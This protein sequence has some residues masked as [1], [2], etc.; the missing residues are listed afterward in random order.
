MALEAAQPARVTSRTTYTCPMHPEVEQ[1]EP[2]SCPL[3][4][5]DL[6]PRRVVTRQCQEDP[7]LRQMTRRFW[8]AVALGIPV[9]L[10]AMLPMWGVPIDQWLGTGV[11]GWLQL[12]LAT[13]VVAWCGAPFFQRGARSL[14]TGHLNMFTL[15]ALGTGAAYLYSLMA[16]LLPGSLPE[17]FRKGGQV[18]LYF[19]A[20]AMITVLVLMGQV[21]ELHHRHRTGAAIRELLALAPPTAR[22]VREGQD[23]T[24]PLD[25][26][27]AGDTLRV[28]PGE[29]VPVDGELLEGRSRVDQSMITGESVPVERVPGDTVI[30]GTLNQTGAFLM[31][32]D[33]VGADTF[34]A[35]IVEMVSTAQRSRAQSN[36]WPMSWPRISS[37]SSSPWRS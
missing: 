23:Q 29:K 10:L 18:H 30:G 31:R 37:R 27:Q 20:A 28:R 8:I 15:I 35:R 14:V 25:E 3:C 12:L 19:E 21:L 16:V 24:V 7:E 17:A 6:E 32:A 26:V 11:L 33:R 1:P 13:P 5:M 36:A 2:G 34:L 9:F 4:G 22:V